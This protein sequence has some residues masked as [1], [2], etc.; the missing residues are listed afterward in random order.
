[1]KNSTHSSFSPS[2][3]QISCVQW[4]QKGTARAETL[5]P[6]S[7]GGFEKYFNGSDSPLSSFFIGL[8]GNSR[9][10]TT[11]WLQ[12]QAEKLDMHQ[13]VT[14]VV[15][16]TQHTYQERINGIG[17]DGLPSS[18]YDLIKSTTLLKDELTQKWIRTVLECNLD[19][20]MK[21][22]LLTAA[23]S[24]SINEFIPVSTFLFSKMV[25]KMP[26]EFQN[27]RVII[28]PAIP[29]AVNEWQGNPAKLIAF[30]NEAIISVKQH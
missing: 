26:S 18:E 21:I 28:F 27:A 14:E 19:A 13:Y 24:G 29:L 16:E 2:K 3:I 15:I 5:L 22:D 6:G 30:K 23:S 8:T 10:E 12:R 11:N 17:A 4:V 7:I 9:F 20:Q 1:M 25:E